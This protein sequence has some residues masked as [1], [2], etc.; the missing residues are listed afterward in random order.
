MP[1]EKRARLSLAWRKGLKV[2]RCAHPD[3]QNE[4]KQTTYAQKYCVNCRL[5]AIVPI[6]PKHQKIFDEF[7]AFCE[8]HAIPRHAVLPK[9]IWVQATRLRTSRDSASTD[10]RGRLAKRLLFVMD[11]FRLGRYI[12]DD[13]GIVFQNPPWQAYCP[14]DHHYCQGAI[15]PGDC[16]R[17]HPECAYTKNDWLGV[18]Q[19]RGLYEISLGEDKPRRFGWGNRRPLI[20]HGNHRNEKPD[21]AATHQHA[22]ALADTQRQSAADGHG[23]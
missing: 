12:L 11:R 22:G 13:E 6:D 5:G 7:M 21:D 19:A 17:R 9:K 18:L 20:G 8:K 23:V 10:F 2:M 16:P 4:F 14:V 1:P 3:C 15:L